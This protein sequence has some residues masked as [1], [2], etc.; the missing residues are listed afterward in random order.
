MSTALA[1]SAAALKLPAG[2]P[3]ADLVKAQLQRDYPPGA[4]GWLTLLAWS[5]PVRVPL[6]QIDRTAGKSEWDA[7][8]ADKA[9]QQLFRKKIASGFRKPVVLVRPAGGGRL[10]AVDGHSRICASDSLGLPVSAY[11]GTAK[12]AHGPWEVAH[13]RQLANDTAA[14]ELAAAGYPAGTIKPRSGMISLDLPRGRVKPVPGGTTDH[15]ITVVYLGE[16]VGDAAFA[17]ACKRAKAAADAAGGPLTGKVGGIGSFPPSAD[18][19]GQRPAFAKVSL[20]GA[21]PLR[22]ALEDLSASEHASWRPHVTIRY[23][24]KDDPLPPPVPPTPV[25]FTHL[26]VHRGKQVA[27]FPLGGKGSA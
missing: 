14:L 23:I 26:S 21:T 6:T 9:K 24:G 20:P 12:T 7:A 17:K 25:T 10:F 5:G 16:D 11:I 3:I 2:T 13:S 22:S 27:R 18:G 19:V 15:H 4:L 8:A 1:D